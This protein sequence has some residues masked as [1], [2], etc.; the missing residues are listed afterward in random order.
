MSAPSLASAAHADPSRTRIFVQIAVIL[1][2]IT[3]LEIGV[4]FMPLIDPVRIALLVV[5]SVVKFL[6]V[7]FIFMHLRWDRA[8]CTILFFIG[9][10]LASGTVA[11]LLKVFK[12]HDSI[13]LSSHASITAPARVQTTA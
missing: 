13:P 1:A 5:F 8:F 10:S 2:V 12:S 4:L 6:L 3:G 11:I 7:I 9:L